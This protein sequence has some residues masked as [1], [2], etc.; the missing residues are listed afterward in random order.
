MSIHTAVSNWQ[1]PE[2]VEPESEDAELTV[3][4]LPG[5]DRHS[6]T[7]RLQLSPLGQSI[8]DDRLTLDLAYGDAT[9]LAHAIRMALS[10]M[11]HRHG[12]RHPA[13][14]G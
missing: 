13:E 2:P 11:E 8:G 6:D 10:T 5:L 14:G 9:S 4:A 3:Q 12:R 7:V 1:R